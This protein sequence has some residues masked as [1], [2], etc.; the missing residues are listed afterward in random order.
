M[1]AAGIA[2][3]QI[4]RECVAYARARGAESE[5]F[6]GL[7]GVGDLTA[8]ILAEGSRNRKAGE[9]LG[10]GTP[11]EQIPGIIGQA[12]EALDSVPLI[13]QAVR[14]SGTGSS[15]LDGLARLIAGEISPSEWMAQ[16]RQA[17]RAMRAA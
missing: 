3:A 13:A 17:E 2:T 9:L 16:V 4:W 7:A 6:A 14:N 5:T 11:A 1:N 10:Q 8:T 12:S 15:A